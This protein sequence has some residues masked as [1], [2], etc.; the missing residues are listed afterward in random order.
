MYVNVWYLCYSIQSSLTFQGFVTIVL[1]SFR[2]T[3]KEHL[4]ALYLWIDIMNISSFN[5]ASRWDKSSINVLS[6]DVLVCLLFFSIVVAVCLCCL[7]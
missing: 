5:L 3:I 2:K 7:L 1:V 4:F 6:E